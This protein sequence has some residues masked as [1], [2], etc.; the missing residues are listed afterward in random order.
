MNGWQ[1]VDEY[2][3]LDESK[4][5]ALVVVCSSSVNPDDRN[6]AEANRLIDKF[7]SKPL[8]SEKINEIMAVIGL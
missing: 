8:S 6:K 5:A 1:F 3:K 7:V 2:E 4:K